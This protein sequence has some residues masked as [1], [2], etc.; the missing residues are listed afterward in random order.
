LQGDYYAADK[1]TDQVQSIAS[2]EN[3][4]LAMLNKFQGY[5]ITPVPLIL[6]EIRRTAEH[7]A[8]IAEAALNQS[9]N[10]ITEPASVYQI[11]SENLNHSLS[12]L[13]TLY[14]DR[15]LSVDHI[16]STYIKRYL[17]ICAF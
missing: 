16:E 1:I 4:I 6:A 3:D 15:M 5:D 13:I 17:I 14:C 11:I 7:G 2:V 8:D 12:H 10:A 9:V